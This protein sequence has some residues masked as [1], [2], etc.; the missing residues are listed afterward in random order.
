MAV[1][2]YTI[3]IHFLTPRST[4]FETQTNKQTNSVAFSPQ[5]NYT[6]RE[7]TS[8]RRSKCKVLLIDGVAWSAQ[9]IPTA[10]NLGFLVQSCY[11]S[12][13][14]ALQLSSRGWVDPVPEPL[15]LRSSAGNRTRVLWICSQE[16]WPLDHRGGRWSYYPLEN[17]YITQRYFLPY[18]EQTCLIY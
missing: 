12:T 16:L 9:R 15:L 2:S 6:D 8:C 10:V 17:N 1:E 4:A 14:V 13:Q 5:A 11:F 7:T 18:P 3:L